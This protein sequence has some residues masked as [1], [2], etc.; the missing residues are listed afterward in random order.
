MRQFLSYHLL[1]IIIFTTPLY[2]YETH[3]QELMDDATC[4]KCHYSGD[5]EAKEEK[6]NSFTKLH[7]QVK[8]CANNNH[9]GWFEEE[10]MDVSDYLN[11]KYYNLPRLKLTDN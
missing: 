6:V 1:Y 10:V 11:S 9:A 7:D 2:T 8:A 3:P 4:M 5:F